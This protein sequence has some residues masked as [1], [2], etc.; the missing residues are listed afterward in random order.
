MTKQAGQ[1]KRGDKVTYTR[2]DPWGEKS[3]TE[4]GI[5]IALVGNKSQRILLDTGVEFH[6]AQ[7]ITLK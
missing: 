5:V 1:L 3:W 2:T 4:T 7:F 6:A